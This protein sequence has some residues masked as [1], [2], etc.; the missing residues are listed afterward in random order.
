MTAHKQVAD[1]AD[2]VTSAEERI[3]RLE[4]LV[5]SLQS[6]NASLRARVYR[7]EFGDSLEGLR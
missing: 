5:L 3:D 2:R 4:Q 7:L 6:E 1:T